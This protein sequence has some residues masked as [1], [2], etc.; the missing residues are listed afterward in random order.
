MKPNH[1]LLIMRNDNLSAYHYGTSDALQTQSYLLPTVRKVLASHPLKRRIIEVGCGNGAN[2]HLLAS[3]GYEVV[4]IDPSIQGLAFARNKMST[5]QFFEASAY[6]D[7]A[8]RFGQFDIVLSLEVVEHVY[9]PRQYARTIAGVLNKDGI[10]IVSTPYHS[11]LKNLVISLT[12]KWDGHHWPLWEGGHI[13][14]WSRKTLRLLFSEVGL[15]EREFY[16]V[17]RVPQLAKSMIM[18]LSYNKEI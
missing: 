4:A 3:A 5:A 18:V 2:A 17:G 6:D 1:S 14:F 11:Y 12:G 13:K 9:Y 15:T 8:G 10:A 16:R 7:L